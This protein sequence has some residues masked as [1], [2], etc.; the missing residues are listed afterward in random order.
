MKH[1]KLISFL[2]LLALSLAILIAINPFAPD[3]KVESS[4]DWREI[5]QEKVMKEIGNEEVEFVDLR[6]KEL[7]VDGHIPGAINIPYEEFQQ[8][9][10]ELS[11]DKRVILICHTGRMGV[12]SAEFLVKQGYEGVANFGGGMAVWDGQLERE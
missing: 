9:T 1:I 7:Y 6:E 3:P 5:D 11:K 10:D 4:Q 2:S 8:R 12:E